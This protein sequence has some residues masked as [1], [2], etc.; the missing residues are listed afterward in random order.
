MTQN[1]EYAAAL[2]LAGNF[3]EVK[4]WDNIHHAF[5][6]FPALCP[7]ARESYEMLRKFGEDMVF[8]NALSIGATPF[9]RASVTGAQAAPISVV[10]LHTDDTHQH[11][12]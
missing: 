10:Q 2:R 6:V 1:E 4:K 5:P 11:A 8:R 9:R 12:P 7:Q 3:V